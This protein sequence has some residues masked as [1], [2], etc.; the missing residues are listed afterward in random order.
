MTVSEEQRIVTSA[1]GGSLTNEVQL[2]DYGGHA[3]HDRLILVG[4]RLLR[5]YSSRG[6]RCNPRAGL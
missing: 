3:A 5:L 1:A 6:D 4:V 2:H